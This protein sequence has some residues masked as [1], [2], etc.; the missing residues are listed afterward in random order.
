VNDAAAPLGSNRDRH[1]NIGEGVLGEKLGTFLAHP[2]LQGLP[3]FLEVPGKDGHGPDEDEVRKLKELHARA[4]G[5]KTV[6]R[7]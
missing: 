4:T 3:A 5:A 7:T 2:K 1:A 6:R